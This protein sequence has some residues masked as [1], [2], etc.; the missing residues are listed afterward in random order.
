MNSRKT[1]FLSTGSMPIISTTAWLALCLRWFLIDTSLANHNSYH[2]YWI[3]AMIHHDAWWSVVHYAHI[4][5]LNLPHRAR[6]W[7]WHVFAPTCACS[8]WHEG[9]WKMVL[10]W[11]KMQLSGKHLQRSKTNCQVTWGCA[12]ATT[13]ILSRY[14]KWLRHTKTL[15]RN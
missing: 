4:C 7:P 15:T 1:C 5:P 6:L 8:A 3:I 11:A 10:S 12:P 13:G 2:N 9:G 14:F